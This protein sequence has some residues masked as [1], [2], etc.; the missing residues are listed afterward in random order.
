MNASQQHISSVANREKT[1]LGWGKVLCNCSYTLPKT[2]HITTYFNNVQV[3]KHGST[4]KSYIVINEILT[5][6][7]P[8]T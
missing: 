5:N 3:F 6:E 7:I 8:E 1:T 2:Q 4:N